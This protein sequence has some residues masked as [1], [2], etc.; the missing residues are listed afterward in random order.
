MDS[1]RISIESLNNQ[2]IQNHQE[3]IQR[4]KDLESRSFRPLH[5]II[6]KEASSILSTVENDT[7]SVLTTRSQID[8]HAKLQTVDH[9]IAFGFAFEED[10]KR[11][12][13]YQRRGF[14]LTE[15]SLP[16]GPHTMS[17][18][19]FSGLSLA[20]I[21][22]LSILNLPIC[23]QELSNSQHY[24]GNVGQIYIIGPDK[25]LPLEHGRSRIRIRLIGVYYEPETRLSLSANTNIH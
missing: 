17:W 16:S 9:S 13:V 1:M 12:R 24:S 14:T 21:S 15:C 5:P 6:S 25:V 4:F 19:I 11:S 2:M 23:L 7:N 22:N 20:Q 8:Q 10:L 3:T 18:S